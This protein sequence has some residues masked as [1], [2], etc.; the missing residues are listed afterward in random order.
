MLLMH[1]RLLLLRQGVQGVHGLI[2]PR[3][4]SLDSNSVLISEQAASVAVACEMNS[5]QEKETVE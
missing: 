5:R 2:V 4:A 3:F 1:E